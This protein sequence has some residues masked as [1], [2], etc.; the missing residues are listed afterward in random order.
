MR[1]SS[2]S[3]PQTRVDRT[4]PPVRPDSPVSGLL[5]IRLANFVLSAGSL[6]AG[7]GRESLGDDHSPASF[8]NAV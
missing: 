1:M 6:L 5:S 4:G 8:Q 2:G 3:M 7:R